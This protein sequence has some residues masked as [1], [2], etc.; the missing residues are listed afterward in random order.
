MRI[1]LIHIRRFGGLENIEISLASGVNIIYGANGSGKT[2]VMAFLRFML[3]GFADKTERDR[4]MPASGG[5]GVAGYITVSAPD[6]SGNQRRYRI[7][8]ECLVSGLDKTQIVAV[9]TGAVVSREKSPG[10]QLL[11]IPRDIFLRSAYISQSDGI[12]FDGAKAGESIENLLFGADENVSTAAALKKL[13][14]R[15][16]ELL[17]KNG[18]GGRISELKDSLAAKEKELEAAEA[19]AKAVL[20]TESRLR[21]NAG[22]LETAERKAETLKAGVEAI[23][24]L[25]TLRYSEEVE[26]YGAFVAAK[27]AELAELRERGTY[28]G[29]L[30]NRKYLDRLKQLKSER[31]M[32]VS[33]KMPDIDTRTPAVDKQ[34]SERASEIAERSAQA[35]GR[36]AVIAELS[37]RYDKTGTLQKAAIV[38]GALT[39]ASIFMTVLF[40]LTIQKMILPLLVADV[41][42]LA[43]MLICLFLWAASRG[44]VTSYLAE[45]DAEDMNTLSLKLEE[46]EKAAAAVTAV[47]KTADENKRRF[48]DVMLRLNKKDE[49][50]NG[51]LS[52][53]GRADLDAAIDEIEELRAAIEQRESRLDTYRAKYK[54]MLASGYADPSAIRAKLEA[55][56]IDA[57]NADAAAM[58]RELDF[59]VKAAESLRDRKHQLEKDLAAAM[60]TTADAA[61]IAEECEAL[62][63]EIEELEEKHGAL[64][65]AYETLDKASAELRARIA[66]SLAETAGKLMSE[67]TS[68]EVESLGVSPELAVSWRSGDTTLPETFMSSGMRDAAY[69]CLRLALL[70][71]TAPQSDPP[72]I[73][74]E[75]FCRMDDD[76]LASVMRL[77]HGIASAGVQIVVFTPH[78]REIEA[79]KT[80]DPEAEQI[81]LE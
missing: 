78:M 74:D 41:A 52:M 14:Q 76:R 23:G 42:L 44:K 46:A 12:A 65:L 47:E 27:K 17:H 60:A 49:E 5:E 54:Q 51:L 19:G 48:E 70:R 39:L 53:W 66:P 34:A 24:Q 56:G 36:Q 32:L 55:A 16:V 15:R 43:A 37:R 25:K 81:V 18:A 31:D 40:A 22:H 21:D 59:A 62:R 75:A 3:Y 73:V 7:E 58:S 20:E 33:E 67:A 28:N 61:P 64:V 80:V 9:A 38:F 6:P 79:L 2:T 13:D 68:G 10:E 77:L 72:L 57:Q 35:G 29:F 1:E 63:E 4:F 8:R 50:I 69:I 30:P 71:L 26:K 11:G 45:W